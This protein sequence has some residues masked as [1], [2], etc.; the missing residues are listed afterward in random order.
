MQ[1]PS[2]PATGY[3]YP[4]PYPNP[5]QPPAASTNG[6]PNPGTA[7][8]Y[9]NHNPHYAPQPNPR[10]VLIRRLFIVFMSF[11]LILGL[12]LFIFFLVVRP[13]LPDVY[14]NSLSVSNFNVSNNQVSGKWDLQVQ[15][16]NPNSKMSLHY[17]TFLCALY[18]HR[19]SL[20]ETRLQ[21][22]DQGKKDET[23]VN[24]TLSVSGT[25]VEGRLADSIG[26]ERG[27]KGSVEF[28]LR[29]V[30]YATFRYGAFRRRRYVTV[31]CDDVAVGVPVSSGSGKMV[32]PA[33]RCKTY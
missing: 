26:K 15:I 25:Y 27:A 9:Q 22:F 1:D 28:D 24:A 14:L 7:Y 31:Y 23:V 33:K 21:P 20:S 12:I 2:R 5:Q 16:R 13:Q 18:Y 17:D 10:A 32:G 19:A 8:P 11:L 6:Y 3:P 29:M 4:Y 30:S